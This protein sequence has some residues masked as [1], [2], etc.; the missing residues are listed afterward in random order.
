MSAAP[1]LPA[2]AMGGVSLLRREYKLFIDRPPQAVFDFF[3]ARKNLARISSAEF[4]EQVLGD[5]E[6]PLSAGAQLTVQ[7]KRASSAA[8]TMTTEISD[9]SAPNGFTEKQIVGPF[10]AWTHRRKFTPFQTGTLLS[11]II[12]YSPS[13]GGPLG[14]LADKIWLGKRLDAFFNGRQQEAKRLLEQFGRIKGRENQ[15]S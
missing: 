9:W 5:V 14:A 3:A 15:Q 4:A 12:E 10:A 1:K 2:S 13:A 7:T 11:E 8:K 6:I